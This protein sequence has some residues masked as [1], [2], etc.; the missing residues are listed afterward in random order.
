[1]AKA[2]TSEATAHAAKAAGLGTAAGLLGLISGIFLFMTVMFGLNEVMQLWLA[3]LVTTL[4]AIVLTAIVASM[5]RT[6]VK[7][8]SPTPQRFL[9]TL[10]EDMEWAKTQLKLS[11]R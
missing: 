8:V 9:R 1:L 6:E 11:A 3:A 4:L 5:A 7:R 2:E 10:K